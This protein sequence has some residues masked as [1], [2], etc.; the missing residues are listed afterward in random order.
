[1]K[2]TL[3]QIKIADIANGYIDNNEEGVY[4]FGGKLNIRPKYQREFV[5]KD[6]QRDEVINTVRKN[7]PLNVMY[8]VKVGEDSYEIL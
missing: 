1:M 7:F 2:I 8:W 5:Y 3:E 6:K 4:G